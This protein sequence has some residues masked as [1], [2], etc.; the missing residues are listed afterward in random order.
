MAGLL[1]NKDQKNTQDSVTDGATGIAKTGTGILGDTL[2]GVTNTVGGVVGGASRGLGETVSGAT[3]QAGKPLGDGVANVGTAVE[4][5][6]QDVGNAA[7]D[8]GQWKTN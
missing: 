6:G 1:N 2:S 4:G 5:T 7:K 3:G 8:A